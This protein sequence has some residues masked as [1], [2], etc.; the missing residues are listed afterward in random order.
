MT[1]MRMAI[2]LPAG[3]MLSLLATATALL[4][5]R[6]ANAAVPGITGGA[7][8]TFNLTATEAFIS[9]P[10]C[11]MVYSWGYGCNGQ[12]GGFAPSTLT[13]TP[14]CPT[15]QIPGPTLIATAGQ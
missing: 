1:S 3:R 2:E 14:S 6:A 13:T 7:T 8:A 15:M 4:L 9:Q 12:P 5:T 10:D 11:T